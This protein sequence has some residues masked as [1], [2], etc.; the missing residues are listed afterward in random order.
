MGKS[1]KQQKLSTPAFEV[2]LKGL[3]RIKTGVC[4][5]LFEDYYIDG[6]NTQLIFFEEM[7]TG[8]G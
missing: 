1:G 8:G 4:V 2:Y 7:T 3:Q 5:T 6:Q